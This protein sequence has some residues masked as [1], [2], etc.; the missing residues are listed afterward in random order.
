M[1]PAIRKV[2]VLCITT[3]LITEVTEVISVPIRDKE[4]CVCR[5]AKGKLML[6]FII[7]DMFIRNIHPAKKHSS[8]LVKVVVINGILKKYPFVL[9]QGGNI[10]IYTLQLC[11]IYRKK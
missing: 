6:T 10:K 3:A 4:T 8:K 11:N 9:N 7:T 5:I 1:V 2:V